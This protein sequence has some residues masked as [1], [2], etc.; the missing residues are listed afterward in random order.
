MINAT[1]RI[2]LWRDETMEDFN[3]TFES[4]HDFAATSV[5]VDTEVENSDTL[6]VVP[7]NSEHDADFVTEAD[8]VAS[9]DETLV[10]H[11]LDVVIS[12]AVVTPTPGNARPMQKG[13]FVMGLM[14]AATGIGLMLIV[15]V[16]ALQSA[17]ASGNFSLPAVAICMVVGLMFLG[18]GFGVMATAAPQFD[19]NEFDRLMRMGDVSPESDAVG[20]EQPNAA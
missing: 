10:S 16:G 12:N 1:L 8:D 5:M 3:N 17:G 14:I 6:S 4:E 18:G 15:A 13:R 7:L 19:D 9:S 20:T 11:A 2:T